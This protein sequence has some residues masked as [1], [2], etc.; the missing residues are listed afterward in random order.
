MPQLDTLS[1]YPGTP[2][3]TI[4]GT[5]PDLGTCTSIVIYITEAIGGNLTATRVISLTASLTRVD[6]NTVTFTMPDFGVVVPT[7]ANAKAIYTVSAVSYF[8]N[9]LAYETDITSTTPPPA[10][11]PTPTY[12]YGLP[13]TGMKFPSTSPRWKF[14]DPY[15]SNSGTNTYTFEFNPDSM[16]SPFPTRTINSAHTTAIDG[17]VLLTEGAPQLAQWKFSG[18]IRKGYQYDMLRSWVY[19]RNRRI[20]VTDHFG[21]VL[22]CVLTQLDAQ[23][24]KKI[25]D[26]WIHS[27]TVS[28]LVISVSQPTQIPT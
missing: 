3:V 18:T 27:Y 12:G 13:N 26:Y 11:P 15:D 21:R 6:Q 9:I 28:G 23:P 2:G 24:L 10:T 16:T 20:E 19:D 25:N 4:T 14:H 17:Q 8:T 22:T 7:A 5:G 1:P